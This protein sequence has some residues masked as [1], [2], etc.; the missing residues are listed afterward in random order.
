MMD[1]ESPTASGDEQSSPAEPVRK[2]FITPV[3]HEHVATKPV[4]PL[5]P[6]PS[7]TAVTCVTCGASLDCANKPCPGCSRSRLIARAS[8]LGFFIITLGMMFLLLIL[9][10]A[11]ASSID[12]FSQFRLSD[13]SENSPAGKERYKGAKKYSEDDGIEGDPERAA[14]VD[15]EDCNASTAAGC[16]QSIT[17]SGG[18]A[19]ARAATDSTEGVTKGAEPAITESSGQRSL[20][21][22]KLQ[23]SA[24]ANHFRITHSGKTILD[25]DVPESMT[26]V[27]ALN[28][29]FRSISTS[30][31]LPDFDTAANTTNSNEHLRALIR[32]GKVAGP[33]DNAFRPFALFS[34]QATTIGIL[35]ASAG[36]SGDGSYDLIFVDTEKGYLTKVS[37]NSPN[38]G[39]SW[40]TLLGTQTPVFLVRNTSYIGS[41]ASGLGSNV[42]SAAYALDPNSHTFRQDKL[43]EFQVMQ[44][45]ATTSLAQ[46]DRLP[47]A[48]LR[49]LYRT[50]ITDF[51]NDRSPRIDHLRKVL[52]LVIDAF[53]YG[54]KSGNPSVKLFE[55][56]DKFHPSIREEFSST[57]GIKTSPAPGRYR[58]N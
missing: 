41:H 58:D 16:D 43:L 44:Q 36:A 3:D 9:V 2:N 45:L 28:N 35:I 5:G 54:S 39:N 4:L 34:D 20:K 23:L 18:S 29:P 7:S 38:L 10:A 48:D 51:S 47:P 46:L 53:Y 55:M 42:V 56:F 6:S 25:E 12:I 19:Q 8:L 11:K 22:G 21:I 27:A 17:S 40:M 26:V 33:W 50:S 52:S 49:D 32:W 24:E 30:D 14:A 1:V 13:S 15:S 37:T 57:F 31:G